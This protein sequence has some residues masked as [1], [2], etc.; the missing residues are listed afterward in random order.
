MNKIFYKESWR[1]L[2]LCVRDL[3]QRRRQWLVLIICF[4]CVSQPLLAGKYAASFLEIGVGARALG[5]GGAFCSLVNDGTSFYWNPAGFAFL[6]KPQLS[7]MYSPQFGSF[8]NPMANY[9]FVGYANPLPSDAVL[10]VNWIRLAV[11][12]IPLYSEL[13]GDSYWDRL[14]NPW[15]RP[16]GEPE[17][18]I[19][20]TED[21]IYFSF[22]IMNHFKLDM[23]WQYQKVRVDFPVGINLKWIRQSLGEN[24]ATGLGLDFGAMIRLHLSDFFEAERLGNFSFGIQFQNLAGTSLSWN[25]RHQDSIP[26]NIKWGFSYQQP[27]W[28]SKNSLSFSFDRDS[29]WNGEKHWGIEYFGF[30]VLGLRLGIAQGNFTGGVG[31]RISVVQIDYAFLSHELGYLHRVSCA[32]TI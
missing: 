8:K 17:G 32:I 24:E 19:G 29:R 23:G 30:G 31:L 18:Y 3:L 25:T 28:N 16:S 10:A 15:L 20:D 1:S 22:A 4:C 26:T 7:G 6:E 9:H 2:R 5:M 12:D 14:H 13:T 21:A 27:L 11:D